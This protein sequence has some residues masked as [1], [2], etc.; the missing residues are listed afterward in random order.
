MQLDAIRRSVVV[1]VQHDECARLMGSERASMRPP[2]SP[3]P[4]AGA[5]AHHSAMSQQQASA[6]P[7]Q[8]HNTGPLL[9]WG[10]ASIVVGDALAALG[11]SMNVQQSVRDIEESVRSI[12]SM[13]GSD[14]SDGKAGFVPMGFGAFFALLGVVLIAIALYN[15]GQTFDAVRRHVAASKTAAEAPRG[16][17]AASAGPTIGAPQSGGRPDA[18]AG[19]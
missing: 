4:D 15:I 2:G 19:R 17:G 16:V 14:V 6:N 7:S 9:A 5:R 12:G 1:G 11:I 8:P 18:S 3:V 13:F 10:V